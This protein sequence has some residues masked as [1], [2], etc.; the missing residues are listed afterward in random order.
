MPTPTPLETRYLLAAVALAEE[1]SFTGAA[2]RLRARKV[3]IM[4]S[5]PPEDQGARQKVG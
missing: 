3:G 1:L 2:K 4:K 5:S